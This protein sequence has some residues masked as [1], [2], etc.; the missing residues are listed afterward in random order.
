M[1]A[2]RGVDAS[3][4][5]FAGADHTLGVPEWMGELAV[6]AMSTGDSRLVRFVT[7]TTSSWPVSTWTWSLAVTVNHSHSSPSV[8]SRTPYRDLGD[9]R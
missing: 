9:I 4:G 2:S 3:H 6:R 8:S 7:A 1:A 5:G